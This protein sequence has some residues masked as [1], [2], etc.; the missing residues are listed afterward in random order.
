MQNAMILLTFFLLVVAVAPVLADQA[1][2]D[3]GFV[4]SSGVKIHF[5]ER[6]TGPLLVLI[7]G[8][9]DFSLSWRHQ[10]PALAEHFHV[11]AP[12]AEEQS[13]RPELPKARRGEVRHA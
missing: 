8:L 12:A 9:P 11:V 13:V 2:T 7:H 6:G 3:Q 5:V 4:D 1:G 10:M